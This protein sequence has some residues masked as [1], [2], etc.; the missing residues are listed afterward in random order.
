MLKA[1]LGIERPTTNIEGERR[2]NMV[3]AL[4]TAL[5][6]LKTG[7]FLVNTSVKLFAAARER[8]L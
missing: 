3:V 7:D 2:R 6:L 8:K 1:A 4:A 5:A